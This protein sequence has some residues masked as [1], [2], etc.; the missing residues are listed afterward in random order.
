MAAA[1]P[2]LPKGTPG[3]MGIYTGTPNVVIG[4][5]WHQREVMCFTTGLCPCTDI[6][7]VAVRVSHNTFPLNSGA[8]SKGLRSANEAC[9][10]D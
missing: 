10:R 1:L 6:S 2:T 7:R 9:A 3:D 4:H 5:G 8:N